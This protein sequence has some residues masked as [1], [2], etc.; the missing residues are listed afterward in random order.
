MVDS[1]VE[2]LLKQSI[3]RSAV[4]VS[5]FQEADDKFSI[6]HQ[7][8]CTLEAMPRPGKLLTA[9]MRPF[10]SANREPRTSSERLHFTL[11]HNW[12]FVLPRPLIYPHGP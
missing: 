8:D 7:I 4:R 6:R 12:V 5:A 10:S 2:A 9:A 11:L 1:I 3:T